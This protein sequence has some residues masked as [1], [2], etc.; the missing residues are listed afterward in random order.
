VA[1]SSNTVTYPITVAGSAV[2]LFTDTAGSGVGDMDLSTDWWLTVPAKAHAG[3]TSV[4]YTLTL[5][6]GP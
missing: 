5:S 2:N 1:A 4:T 6:Y 3:T